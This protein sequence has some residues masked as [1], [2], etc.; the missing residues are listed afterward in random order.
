MALTTASLPAFLS[1]EHVFV[2]FCFCVL[3]VLEVF[4]LNSTLLFINII[5]IVKGRKKA[6]K[7]SRVCIV[8]NDNGQLISLSQSFDG[9]VIAGC[10]SWRLLKSS[11]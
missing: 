1:S 8:L 4:G 9:G 3:R 11:Y 10:R 5:N 6:R 2:F 7:M